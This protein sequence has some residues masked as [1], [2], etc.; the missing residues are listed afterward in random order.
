MIRV[1]GKDTLAEIKGKVIQFDKGIN[2][3]EVYA[4]EGMK[5]RIVGYV[6]NM[7]SE[8]D[9]TNE[10]KDAETVHKLLVDYSEFEQ[11]NEKYEESNYYDK[12]GNPCLTAREAGY[13]NVKDEIYMGNKLPF[14]I[15]TE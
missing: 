4:E 10:S 12:D 11:H 7:Y 2:L 8:E 5:A 14:D 6:Y 1:T 15:V 3:Y 9:P 13:Y